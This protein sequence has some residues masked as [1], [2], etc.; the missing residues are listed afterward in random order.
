VSRDSRGIPGTP[1]WTAF[2]AFI[3]VQNAASKIPRSPPPAEFWRAI[4]KDTHEDFEEDRDPG[5]LSPR[6]VGFKDRPIGIKSKRYLCSLKIS[7]ENERQNECFWRELVLASGQ[8]TYNFYDTLDEAGEKPVDLFRWW[9][10]I[11]ISGEDLEAMRLG[12]GDPLSDEELERLELRVDTDVEKGDARSA[13]LVAVEYLRRGRYVEAVRAASYGMKAPDYDPSIWDEY[14]EEKVSERNIQRRLL[15]THNRAKG[16]SIPRGV[17]G[18]L[19]SL[20]DC[21]EADESVECLKCKKKGALSA[22]CVFGAPKL[23]YSCRRLPHS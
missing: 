2:D 9:K 4:F 19:H 8:G 13:E 22:E 6:P 15:E 11:F 23:C 14:R 7:K 1:I 5:D 21:G 16:R 20:V 18:S 3:A 10:I 12:I 17:D